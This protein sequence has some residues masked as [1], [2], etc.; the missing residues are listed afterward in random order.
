MIEMRQCEF[1]G[2]E[3]PVEV[4]RRGRPRKYCNHNHARAAWFAQHPLYMSRYQK[5]YRVGRVLARNFG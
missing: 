1:C 2:S 5:R 4:P 3:F